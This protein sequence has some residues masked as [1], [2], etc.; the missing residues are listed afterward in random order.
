MPSQTHQVSQEC[1]HNPSSVPRSKNEDER[2]GG[3]ETD[4]SLIAPSNTSPHTQLGMYTCNR[5]DSHT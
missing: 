1:L 5:Y 4:G 3:L 2:P